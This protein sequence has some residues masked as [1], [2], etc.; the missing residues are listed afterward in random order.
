MGQGLV[1]RVAIVEAFAFAEGLCNTG[2]MANLECRRRGM[3]RP[4]S[5]LFLLHLCT[6]CGAPTIPEATPMEEP[7][8]AVDGSAAEDRALLDRLNAAAR[9]GA[10]TETLHGTVV[11]D[12]YRSLEEDTPETRAWIEAQ[13]N[14]ARGMLDE[15]SRPEAAARLDTLLSIGVIGGAHAAGDTIFYTK[16]E[17]DEEQPRLLVRDSPTAEPRVLI[18][19]AVLGERVA[20]DWFYPSPAGTYVAYG[21]STNG[22]ERSTLHVLEVATGTVSDLRI[23]GTKWCNLSWLHGEDGFYY[24]RYPK[25]GEDGYDADAEDTY[26][27]RIFFHAFTQNDPVD[28][29]ENDAL[30][31]G[32]EA[33]TD[34]PGAEVSDDDRFVTLNVFR[35]WS[36]SDVYLL[37][38]GRSPSRR[39][40]GPTEARPLVEVVKG[41][42]DLTVGS[43]Y[44]GQLYLWTNIDAPRY[45]IA[46]VRP[47]SAGDMSAW[48]DLVPETEAPI[49]HWA[50]VGGQL[51]LHYLDDVQSKV[52]LVTL[53]GAS[54]REVELPGAGS[55]GG[56]SGT[57]DGNS[58]AFTFSSYT[59]PPSLLRYD[60]GAEQ[61][62]ELD[63]VATDVDFSG[64]EVTRERVA[65]ADGTMIPV[66]LV[67]ARG[68]ERDGERPV[69]LYG[70]GGFN[71]SLMPGFSRNALYWVERGGVYAVA[72]IRGGGEFG[73]D[74]HTAGNLGNKEHVFEDF[75]AVIR[76]LG[77]GGVSRPEGI[78]ISGGS[79]GGLLMGAMLTRC[80]AAFAAATT[81]VGLYDMVRYDRFPPAELWVSEYGTAED[82]EQFEWLHGYSPY[83]RVPVN[84]RFP[85]TLV[86]TADHDSR[87]FWGHSTKFAARLQ[88]HQVGDAP[89]LFYMVRAVGHGA[90]TRRSDLVDRYVRQYAFIEHALGL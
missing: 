85:A 56:L 54:T 37:D 36:A 41:R 78:A 80:P 12:P 63:R 55:V 42:D 7:S 61:L 46:R 65:S 66:T 2:A 28:A 69:L 67:H 52:Q 14:R 13:A 8:Q 34:F 20:L 44:D 26:F 79:N 57:S 84:T 81:Y 38:R 49:E 31:F 24:T 43:V 17:G 53:D 64:L 3:A 73:E 1:A 23:P 25:A 59:H 60:V 40:A 45:R 11:E 15:W 29:A 83:H 19:P 86:E 74:W 4:L 68:M 16:R 51:F 90:G 62:T 82:P 6:A 72:N 48:T 77:T 30:V 75:E 89:I 5:A 9:A 87:V 70:Y 76:W 88:E 58:V 32:A 50:I 71:V 22:D 39:V 27:P 47:R 21:L 18:D 35:G 33:R 10:A